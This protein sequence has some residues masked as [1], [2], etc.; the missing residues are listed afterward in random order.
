VTFACRGGP[1][2]ARRLAD[3]VRLVANAPSLG[4]V[5]S[6]LSL[7]VHTS[8]ASTPPAEREASGVTD[9]LV[10]LSVGLE[11]AADLVADLDRAL[12]GPA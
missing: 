2:A 10:R 6:L 3:S 12:G 7:P 1:A 11:D 9:D 4:G 8:H 5:E